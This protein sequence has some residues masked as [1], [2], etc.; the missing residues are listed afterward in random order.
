VVSS[1]PV[2][3]AWIASGLRRDYRV[4][5][6]PALYHTRPGL[7]PGRCHQLGLPWRCSCVCPPESPKTVF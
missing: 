2:G 5:M 6:Q 1:N 3:A 7:R 4:D